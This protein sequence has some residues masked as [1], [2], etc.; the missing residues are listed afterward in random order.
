MGIQQS[1]CQCNSGTDY[2]D[3]KSLGVGD[4]CCNCHRWVCMQNPQ[5]GG[6]PPQGDNK[7][8]VRIIGLSRN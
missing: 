7:V 3:C 5:T 2:G 8:D 6:V 1:S 4:R